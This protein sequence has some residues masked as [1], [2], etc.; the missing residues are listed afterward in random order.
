M[1]FK[2]MPELKWLYSY[3]AWWTFSLLAS[4]LLYR[5]FRRNGWL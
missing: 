4:F 5:A 3:P 2:H 1:N